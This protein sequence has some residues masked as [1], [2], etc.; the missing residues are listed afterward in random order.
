MRIVFSSLTILM[1]GAAL[2]QLAPSAVFAAPSAADL[3][4]QA[5]DAEGGV[6]ALRGVQR[7][8][9]TGAAVHWEP[10]QSFRAMGAGGEPKLAGDSTFT[11]TWD[12]ESGSARTDWDRAM[13]IPA[14]GQKKFS[15]IV[16]PQLG[17]VKDAVGDHPM[18]GIRV[19]THL[20]EL[21]RASPLLLL[22]AL[23]NP[24][25][26]RVL[27]DQ[28]LGG[29]A[30]PAVAFNDGPTRFIILFDAASHLPLAVRTR[31][32]D[33]LLGDSNYDLILADWQALGD[34]KVARA[35]TYKLNDVEIAKIG[36]KDVAAAASSDAFAIPAAVKASATPPAQG[37]VPYQWVIRRLNI[38]LFSDSDAVNF[39]PGGA[40]KL[41]ELAPN[42]QQVVGGSHNSLIVARK[43]SL[44]VFDAPINEWQSRWTI[45]A[46]KAKYPG[47]PIKYL[48]LT[49]H[50]MDHT[51]GARTYVAEGAVV[52][53]PSPD[54]AHFEKIFRAAHTIVPDELQKK[55]TK[56]TV[57][58][59]GEQMTLND[60]SEEIRLFNIKNPH[61]DGMIL[62]YVAKEKIIWVTDLYSPGRDKQINP[63]ILAV[64]EALKKYGLQPMRF[65][66]GHGSNGT[67]SEFATIVSAK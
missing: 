42:V 47:K 39:E 33:Y 62:G 66:G 63:G 24:R 60:S 44:V 5:V 18:S 31:D 25:S 17:Y 16:T 52:I 6:A 37:T 27:S 40:L 35:L 45:D 50:H 36:Y 29:T 4:K 1:V 56:A 34:A 67:A 9:I 57:H 49:H 7:L 26:L 28:T 59:V 58:E 61:V 32:D 12:L 20:R 2:S 21:E 41:V 55:P 43:D 53:V 51:G 8:T 48:V 11:L 65:A 15:E 46:A 38:A 14:P 54:K 3:V 64:N 10:E 22:K 13:Q 19:A 30:Y 23:D